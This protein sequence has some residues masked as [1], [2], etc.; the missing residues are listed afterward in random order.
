MQTTERAPRLVLRGL[1][2]PLQRLT[3]ATPAPLPA[4]ELTFL[5]AGKQFKALQR[6]RNQS[7]AAAEAA[8]ELAYQCPDFDHQDARLI[9]AVQV[10]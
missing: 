1:L 4:F 5:S 7:A 2:P 6:A 8:I 3:P 9:A 10:Q